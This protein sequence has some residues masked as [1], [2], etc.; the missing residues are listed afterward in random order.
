MIDCAPSAPHPSRTQPA[1]SSRADCRV[2]GAVISGAADPPPDA[3]DR[4][5]RRS[6]DSRG[7]W[8]TTTS[9]RG[10]PR[11]AAVVAPAGDPRGAASSSYVTLATCPS[12]TSCSSTLCD[13]RVGSTEDRPSDL[14]RVGDDVHGTR[15]CVHGAE[16]PVDQKL[17]RRAVD[18][19]VRASKRDSVSLA[20]RIVKT[21]E[22]EK[23]RAP[24]VGDMPAQVVHEH[25]SAVVRHARH[26]LRVDLAVPPP[27]SS[28]ARVTS[29]RTDRWSPSRARVPR[30]TYARPRRC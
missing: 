15:G 26:V 25:Q 23:R 1:S 19:N 28:V 21:D 5:L 12:W 3:G 14:V 11:R 29:A 20:K 17:K 27:L 16:E 24:V 22:G 2:R 6:T 4:V 9:T 13:V 7:T 8:G 10:R 18:D 30:P